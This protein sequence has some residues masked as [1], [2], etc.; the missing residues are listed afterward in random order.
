MDITK[1]KEI[2]SGG[3]YAMDMRLAREVAQQTGR[4]ETEVLGVLRKAYKE[5][6]QELS[7][8]KK[9]ERALRFSCEGLVQF[10]EQAHEHCITD[11]ITFITSHDPVCV[12]GVLV[13]QK[14][15]EEAADASR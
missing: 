3:A 13:G 10:L 7:G 5:R 4:P 12:Y 8:R 15:A 14:C 6:V 2:T 11:M 9:E 1:L